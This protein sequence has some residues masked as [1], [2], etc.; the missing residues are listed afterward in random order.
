MDLIP[1]IIHA[2]YIPQQ[3]EKKRQIIE[4]FTAKSDVEAFA[5]ARP[6]GRNTMW[7]KDLKKN[8]HEKFFDHYKMK[9]TPWINV[10]RS[11]DILSGIRETRPELLLK[12]LLKLLII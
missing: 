4:A 11:M 2:Y 9:S 7:R 5:I 12:W 3:I 8:K 1:S 6:S 10:L